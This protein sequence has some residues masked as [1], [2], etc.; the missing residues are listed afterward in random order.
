MLVS[1]GFVQL[2]PGPVWMCKLSCP[3]SVHYLPCLVGWE[4]CHRV[5]S[6]V[7]KMKSAT[8]LW[9]GILE[10]QRSALFSLLY[11][12]QNGKIENVKQTPPPPKE[13]TQPT[14]SH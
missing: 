5:S 7:G 13:F 6:T 1:M 4:G 8:I 12:T 2:L 11:L 14:H 9:R 3:A 10:A